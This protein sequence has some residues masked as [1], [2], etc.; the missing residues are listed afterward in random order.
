MSKKVWRGGMI[1]AGAWSEVQLTAWAGVPNAE[2]VALCD[3]HPDRRDPV[4]QHYKIPQVFDQFDQM[5]DE[6][7]LDFVDI[8]T[9]PYSHASLIHAA[10]Q[11]EL[12][13]LCQKPFCTSLEEARQVDELS[14]KTGIRLM[15]NEN[16]R[17][18]AWYRKAKEL[19]N[20]GALGTPF[21]AAIHK[22]VR[23]TLPEFRHPQTY[24]VEMPQ[25]ILYEV[26]VHYLDTFR[27]LFGEP[28]SVF[29][30][31]HHVSPF[32][33][34]E[35]VQWI[36][37]NFQGLTGLVH[38]SWASIPVPGLDEPADSQARGRISPPRLEIEGTDGTLALMGDGCMHL[39]T[40]RDHRQWQ[41]DEHT[42]VASHVSAQQHFIDCLET[43]AEF[44]T[45]ATETIKTMAL[46]YASY[47]SAQEGR[48]VDPKQMQ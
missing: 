35:D 40:D 2:I 45:S 3:R 21:L 32:M 25:L 7:Q 18:Q 47:L 14:R 31:L 46:V 16:F 24:M 5:L 26:G 12:P 20:A 39:V 19:L 41:F 15:V 4:A 30:R 43:G 28:D 8:C 29:A 48:L 23:L 1:G 6:A 27:F 42:T 22:R 37:L 33:K 38:T 36:T 44:E 10:A 13:V 17:W 34:G 9:R 11:R